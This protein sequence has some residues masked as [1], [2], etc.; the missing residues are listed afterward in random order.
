MDENKGKLNGIHQLNFQAHSFKNISLLVE[1]RES[2][3]KTVILPLY[4]SR[5]YIRRK[6]E[7]LRRAAWNA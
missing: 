4:L 7:N 3:Q 6:K 5:F 1:D 2:G